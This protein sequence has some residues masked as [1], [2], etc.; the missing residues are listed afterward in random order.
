MG[1]KVIAPGV[2]VNTDFEVKIPHPD[3]CWVLELKDESGAVI[4]K[5][6]RHI[7]VFTTEELLRTYA[8]VANVPMDEFHPVAYPWVELVEKCGKCFPGVIIDHTGEPGFFQT[9]PL[10]MGI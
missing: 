1:F 7:Y 4:S 10:Q 3:P 2:L 8:E 6:T 5:D 9:V